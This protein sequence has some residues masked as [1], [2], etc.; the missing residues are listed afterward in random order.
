MHASVPIAHVQ[1]FMVRCVIA[2]SVEIVSIINRN[3]GVGGF[4]LAALNS[5]V[6]VGDGLKMARR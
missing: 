4:D 2:L 3:G 6:P 5:K 1:R